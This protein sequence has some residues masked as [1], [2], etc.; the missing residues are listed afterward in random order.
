M[1]SEI[2]GAFVDVPRPVAIFLETAYVILL[3]L[4]ILASAST[5][6][7]LLWNY[8]GIGCPMCTSF[9]ATHTTSDEMRYIDEESCEERGGLE[10]E[11]DTEEEYMRR[12]Y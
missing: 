12:P 1:S 8:L 6:G 3:G 5:A 2:T 9:F 10:F 4:G 7:C 11:D